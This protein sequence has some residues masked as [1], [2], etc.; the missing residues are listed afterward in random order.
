MLHLRRPA[1]RRTIDGA[2]DAC[3]LYN[4]VLRLLVRVTIR[5]DGVSVI[6]LGAFG[7]YTLRIPDDE[8]R[9]DPVDDACSVTRFSGVLVVVHTNLTP[10]HAADSH[11][12][13]TKKLTVIA[14]CGSVMEAYTG[15]AVGELDPE[16][17]GDLSLGGTAVGVQVLRYRGCPRRKRPEQKPYWELRA[18]AARICPRVRTGEYV[19]PE[20]VEIGRHLIR[21]RRQVGHG[22][23]VEAV[24]G[25]RQLR[26]GS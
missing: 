8:A 12:K 24:E 3:S 6:P 18:R 23:V 9:H 20:V 21:S 25:A 10:E 7:P 22:D 14:A 16:S 2:A 5:P 11:V 4:F 26:M 19:L 13:P 17:G 1:V 15:G